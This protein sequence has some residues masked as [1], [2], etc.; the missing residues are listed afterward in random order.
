VPTTGF[1]GHF[2]A[3]CQQDGS[4]TGP[5]LRTGPLYFS[6]TNFVDFGSFHFTADGGACGLWIQT[7]TDSTG[8][9]VC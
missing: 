5:P 7:P 4:C 8:D 9:I 1:I 3:Q 6:R 2:D